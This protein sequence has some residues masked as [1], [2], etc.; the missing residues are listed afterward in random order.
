MK[1]Y[2]VDIFA[3]NLYKTAYF[4]TEAEAIKYAERMSFY[5]ITFL[6]E[7]II[8]EKYDVIRQI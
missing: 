7:E 4:E 8:D 6:L 1:K 5:G 3:D 2:R